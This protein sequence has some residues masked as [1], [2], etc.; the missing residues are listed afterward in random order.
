MNEKVAED[1][2]P[3]GFKLMFHNSIS[4]VRVLRLGQLGFH[5]RFL[6]TSSHR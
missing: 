3:T 5:S 2:P 4:S 6:L 1:S